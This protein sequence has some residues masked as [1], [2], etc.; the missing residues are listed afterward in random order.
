MVAAASVLSSSSALRTL[1]MITPQPLYI[2]AAHTQHYEKQ[3]ILKKLQIH[4]YYC[5]QITCSEKPN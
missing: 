5:E 3:Q 2:S 1:E 4:V